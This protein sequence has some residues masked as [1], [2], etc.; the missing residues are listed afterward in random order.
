M[1]FVVP[2]VSLALALAAGTA[3]A[4]AFDPRDGWELYRR[5]APAETAKC[6]DRD[7]WPRDGGMYE[8]AVKGSFSSNTAI[9]GVDDARLYYTFVGCGAD[10]RGCTALVMTANVNDVYG[11]P[12]PEVARWNAANPKCKVKNGETLF[13]PAITVPLTATTRLADIEAARRAV[14]ACE[15]KFRETL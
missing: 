13:G 9:V 1:R 15:V 14:L 10:K 2:A 5:L 6:T 11:R 4:Q 12:E 8:T 7:C 3:F